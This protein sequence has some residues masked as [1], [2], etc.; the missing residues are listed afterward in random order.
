MKKLIATLV[1][2][3]LSTTGLV[4]AQSAT[5]SATDGARVS[6]VARADYGPQPVQVNKTVKQINQVV[7][8][9]KPL[10]AAKAKKL[11]K[12]LKEYKAAGAISAKQYKQLTKK[13][14]KKVKASKKR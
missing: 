2:T 12:T 8:A 10:S 11:I 4:M 5:A 9:D 3:I 1:A 14:N 13:I 7:K 6:A